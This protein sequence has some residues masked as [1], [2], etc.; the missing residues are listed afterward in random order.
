MQRLFYNLDEPSAYSRLDFDEFKK[1]NE[2]ISRRKQIVKRYQTNPIISSGLFT[3]L[4]ADTIEAYKNDDGVNEG[5]KYILVLIDGL[6]RQLRVFPL[7]RK[8]SLETSRALNF[9]FMRMDLPGHTL[10]CTDRGVEFE[11]ETD[12]VLDYWGMTHVKMLGQHKSAPAERV[13]R[14]LEDRLEL[15]F[16]SHKNVRRWYDCLSK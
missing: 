9:M 14:T 11:G 4:Y 15:Y 2:I 1:R 12:K 10:F 7:V 3:S 16:A 8:N 6:S 5:F 13:I